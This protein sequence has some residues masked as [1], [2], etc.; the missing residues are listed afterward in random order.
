M[1]QVDNVIDGSRSDDRAAAELFHLP[2]ITAGLDQC[3]RP[4]FVTIG[5]LVRQF[6]GDAE[7]GAVEIDK[8]AILVEKNAAD[9]G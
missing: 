1:P 7:P 8:R 9:L 3:P 6:H 4:R 5:R 2:I